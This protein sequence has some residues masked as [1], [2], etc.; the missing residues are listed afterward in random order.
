[1]ASMIGN[2]SYTLPESLTLDLGGSNSCLVQNRDTSGQSVLVEFETTKSNKSVVLTGFGDGVRLDGVKSVQISSVS[3]SYPV[4]IAYA[5]QANDDGAT[6]TLEPSI[7]QLSSIGTIDG[8]NVLSDIVNT[9]KEGPSTT[10]ALG[11]NATYTSP[12]TPC[13][14]YAAVIASCYSDQDC[15][16]KL[17]WSHSGSSSALGEAEVS[18]TITGGSLNPGLVYYNRAAY[19]LIEIVNGSTAQ[20]FLSASSYIRRI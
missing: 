16:L 19:Y 2:T 3:G 9:W 5:N 11:A 20:S 17:K 14:D 8:I 10:T 18:Q 13:T 1:M 6:V 4:T 15:T 7:K 12:W